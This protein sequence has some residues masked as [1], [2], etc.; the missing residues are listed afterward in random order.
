MTVGLGHQEDKADTN[1]VE[2]SFVDENSVFINETLKG[3]IVR[4][5]DNMVPTIIEAR[6]GLVIGLVVPIHC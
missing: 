1:E 4:E 3:F 6:D 2:R 5:N